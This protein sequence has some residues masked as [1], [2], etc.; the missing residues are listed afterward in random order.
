[1]RTQWVLNVSGLTEIFQTGSQVSINQQ[2]GE[3]V[4]RWPTAMSMTRGPVDF[5]LFE[6]HNVLNTERLPRRLRSLISILGRR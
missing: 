6:R 1:M 5:T 2:S 4:C 3:E